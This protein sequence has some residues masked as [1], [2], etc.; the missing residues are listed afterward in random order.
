MTT[1]LCQLFVSDFGLCAFFALGKPRRQKS[2][3]KTACLSSLNITI[4]SYRTHPIHA[5][6][7]HQNETDNLHDFRISAN[8]LL[9]NE[10]RLILCCAM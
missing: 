1:S 8:E 6:R 2:R 4:L 5:K 7:D 9:L 3:H 10:T